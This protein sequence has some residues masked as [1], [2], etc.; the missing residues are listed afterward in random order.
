[1]AL[2][3]KSTSNVNVLLH[4]R[5]IGSCKHV[6]GVYYK[7]ASLLDRDPFLLFQL[8]GMSADKLQQKLKASPLGKALIDQWGDNTEQVVEYHSYRYPKPAL[9]PLPLTDLKTFWQGGASLPL[10]DNF[11]G[12]PATAAVLIKKGGDYPAFWHTDNSFIEVMEIIYPRIVDKNKV[13][14]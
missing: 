3:R 2:V 4:H 6:A 10:V 7:V 12:K 14:L 8:R 1:M 13:S 5:N 9:K 11:T